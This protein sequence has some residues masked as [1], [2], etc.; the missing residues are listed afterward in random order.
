MSG[1]RH[2]LIVSQLIFINEAEPHQTFLKHRSHAGPPLC[3]IV[4]VPKIADPTRIIVAPCSIA[5]SKS[6]DIPIDNV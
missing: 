2:D 1:A 3:Y 4:L 6:S 5:T